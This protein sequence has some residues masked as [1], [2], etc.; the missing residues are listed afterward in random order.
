MSACSCY[1]QASCD[2]VGAVDEGLVV[3]AVRAWYVEDVDVPE[4]SEPSD[5]GPSA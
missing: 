5:S 1:Q 3:Y 2:G 4:G